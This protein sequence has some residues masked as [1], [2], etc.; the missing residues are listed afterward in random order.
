MMS[1]FSPMNLIIILAVT[2]MVMAAIVVAVIATVHGIR[3]RAA[4]ARQR[5]LP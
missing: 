4:R 1:N 2:L 5:E 3:Q